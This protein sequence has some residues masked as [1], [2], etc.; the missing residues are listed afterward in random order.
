MLAC[1][2]HD[3]WTIVYVVILAFGA[4][5]ITGLSLYGRR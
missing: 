5:A 2:I 4:G 1:A 3:P